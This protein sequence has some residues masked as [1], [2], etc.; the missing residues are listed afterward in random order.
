MLAQL[1][2]FQCLQNKFPSYNGK[3]PKRTL[4]REL[5]MDFQVQYIYNYVTKLCMQQTKVIQNPFI[6]T[7]QQAVEAHRVVRG[8]GSLIF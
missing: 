2:N 8:R 7:L 6:L 1:G 4:V 5:H 3:Y